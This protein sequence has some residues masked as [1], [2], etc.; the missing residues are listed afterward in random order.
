MWERALETY[1]KEEQGLKTMLETN[2]ASTSKEVSKE[3]KIISDWETVLSGPK[4][5]PNDSYWG[6]MCAEKDFRMFIAIRCVFKI[7]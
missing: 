7:R 4:S 6:L 1:S 2:V 3:K 5:I